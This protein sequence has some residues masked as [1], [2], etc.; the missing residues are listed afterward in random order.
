MIFLGRNSHWSPGW[1]SGFVPSS[2]GFTTPQAGKQVCICI[3]ESYAFAIHVLEALSSCKFAVELHR[4]VGDNMIM[5]G[6]IIT[7]SL[8][9]HHPPSPPH[10]YP[11]SHIIIIN[12]HRHNPAIIIII[13][14]YYK[15]NEQERE[16]KY[17]MFV[18]F[19][20][21]HLIFIYRYFRDIKCISM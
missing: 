2:F 20:T 8:S 16:N 10:H 9:S 13:T 17:N 1:I 21:L 12:Y 18:S 6:P 7:S 19:N 5:E 4:L 11:S 15:W 3:T 14:L